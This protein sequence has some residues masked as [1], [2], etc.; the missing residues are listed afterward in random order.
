MPHVASRFLRSLSLSGVSCL[1][2]CIEDNWMYH[3]ALLALNTL[4]RI[5]RNFQPRK[6]RKHYVYIIRIYIFCVYLIF[7]FCLGNVN[8]ALN[9]MT[10]STSQGLRFS[11]SFPVLKYTKLRTSINSFAWLLL[12][13]PPLLLLFWAKFTRLG[14]HPP[15]LR[16]F[17]RSH[18]LHP[19]SCRRRSEF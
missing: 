10:F 11:F 7:V 14:N 18:T 5:V 4:R 19:N 6:G 2:A 12:L 17:K 16:P 15:D 13:L 9:V 3:S 8:Y 1:H